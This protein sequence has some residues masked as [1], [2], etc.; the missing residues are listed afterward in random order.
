MGDILKIGM[1]S[2]LAYQTALTV[3]SQNMANVKTPYYS[4]RLV[5]FTENLRNN[6]VSISDI[7]RVY[8]D[9][10]SVGL[11]YSNSNLGYADI[12]QQ[13]LKQ[14]LSQLEGDQNSVG[15]YI[16][17]TLTELRNLN[18]MVSKDNN[19]SLFID[20]LNL[21]V[22]RFNS[23][24]GKLQTQQSDINNSIQS[25]VDTVNEITKQIANVNRQI[26]LTSNQD[27]SSLKDQREAL[28][29][30]LAEYCNFSRQEDDSGH[31]NILLGNGTIVVADN[32]SFDLATTTNT[33][34]P[35]QLDIVLNAGTSSIKITSAFTSGAIGGYYNV[36]NIQ[37]QQTQRDLDRLAIAIASEFNNQS[38]LGLDGYN[39]LGNNI[40]TDINNTTQI[41]NRVTTNAN[42]TGSL[43]TTV[44][45]DDVKQL[46]SDSY[47]IVFDTPTH[48]V[49]NRTNGIQTTQVSTGTIASIPASI[50]VDGFTFNINSGTISAGDQYTILPANNFANSIKVLITDPKKLALAWPVTTTSNVQNTGTGQASVTDM[51]DTTTSMFTTT[52]GALSP[53]LQ[54]QFLTPTT[55]QIVNAT[56]SAVIEGPIVYDPVN[57]SNVF[58]TPAAYDPG[59]RI[60][61]Q[62]TPKTGDKFDITYNSTSSTS[63]NGSESADNRNGK[64]MEDLFNKN[65]INN[66]LTFKG[67]YDKLTNDVSNSTNSM[68][69]YYNETKGLQQK[70]LDAYEQESGVSMDEEYVNLTQFQQAY[71]A[72]A[73]II[74]VAKS[75]FDTIIGFIRG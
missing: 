7:R 19:R 40:F 8:S 12:N 48:Y 18:N 68:D 11:Q 60:F 74:E 67:S 58:P 6:G 22:G 73:Q 21:L 34:N 69:I 52:P 33:V 17:N 26:G 41:N 72:N 14:I 51:T 9:A 35:N 2:V 31:M 56:T 39:A 70:A 15:A 27:T 62:G 5:D 43:S 16:T 29:Q 10:M 49:M 61:I 65:V 75:V 63:T 54:I 1:N 32:I 13:Q 45:V 37:L 25:V 64:K 50:S 71:Q 44:V 42:N 66:S 28:L 57:G 59:F 47:S 38:K 3:T 46:T 36:Q 23:V 53:P 30:Q 4:R 20:K 24:S 55:Y